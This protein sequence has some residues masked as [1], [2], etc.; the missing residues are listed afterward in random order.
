MIRRDESV[1]SGNRIGVAVSGDGIAVAIARRSKVIW[2]AETTL[3]APPPLVAPGLASAPPVSPKVSPGEIESRAR[4]FDI[5]LEAALDVLLSSAP[6]R[7]VRRSRVVVALGPSLM[8]TK[9][10]PGVPTSVSQQDADRL[11][12]GNTA[13][14]FAVG[15]DDEPIATEVSAEHDG[16][17]WG[18]AFSRSLLRQLESS[19]GKAGVRLEAIVPSVTL[20]RDTGSPYG[21]ADGQTA[22][23]AEFAAGKLLSVRRMQYG[24][25]SAFAPQ[26]ESSAHL[27]PPQPARASLIADATKAATLQNEP[28]AFRPGVAERR[29]RAARA[30]VVARWATLTSSAA[31]ALCAPTIGYSLD[32]AR[33]SREL[34][35]LSGQRAEPLRNLQHV[36][37]AA[38]LVRELDTFSNGAVPVTRVMAL[39]TERLP[40]EAILLEFRIDSARV[41]L[42]VAAPRLADVM[43]TLSDPA[44]PSLI[45]AAVRVGEGVREVVAGREVERGT[46]ELRIRGG[47]WPRSQRL[48]ASTSGATA[49]LPGPP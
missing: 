8:A 10:L 38:A 35:A 16:H 45:G 48:S 20:H 49:P 18:A 33:A 44:E 40:S 6:P 13:Q 1:R 3:G 46:I 11:L 30:R 36:R 2:S 39:I 9:P 26:R 27:A 28:M 31:F 5:D 14:F 4:D 12:A 21:A 23:F 17:W 19:S 24:T 29:T 32:A 42:T 47:R 7:Q 34:R 43:E 15:A 22:F 41:Q 37:T 25:A